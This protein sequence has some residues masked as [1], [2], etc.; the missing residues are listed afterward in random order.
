M[1]L[2]I[3]VRV[4]PHASDADLAGAPKDKFFTDED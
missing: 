3:S 1:F 2:C 4:K